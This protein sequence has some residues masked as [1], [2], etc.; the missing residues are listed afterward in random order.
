MLAGAIA[1][2]ATLA[3][4]EGLIV[5]AKISREN[6]ELLAA[7]AIAWDTAWRMLVDE[8]YKNLEKE[9]KDSGV[10]E[11]GELHRDYPAKTVGQADCPVLYNDNAETLCRVRTILCDA[12]G[13]PAATASDGKTVCICVNL[14][15][16]GDGHRRSLNGFCGV[17]GRNC[18]HRVS[19]IKGKLDREADL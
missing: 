9:L 8:K 17:E 18:G 5:A 11:Y 12:S 19:V 4:M 3:L 16:G 2:L 14:E 6:S 1:G 13:F 10:W 7:D 15:W